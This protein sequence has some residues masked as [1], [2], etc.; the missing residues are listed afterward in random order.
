MEVLE[1]VKDGEEVVTGP[2]K[3]LATLT[4]GAAVKVQSES[5]A[6]KRRAK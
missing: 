5:E 4:P 1:G 3:A 2:A 6:L